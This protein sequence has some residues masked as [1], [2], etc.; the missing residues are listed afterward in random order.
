MP[1]SHAHELDRLPAWE[2]GTVAVLSTAG[3]GPPHAIPV[4]TGVRVGDH[5]LL[6]ALAL[7]RESLTRLRDDPS[8]ALT[9]LARGVACTAHGTA[10]ILQDPMAISDKVAAVAVDISSI[11]DHD[12]PRFKIEAGVSWS[13]TDADA[14]QRDGEIRAALAQLAGGA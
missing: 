12:Q 11:Q 2:L 14:E 8:C 3:S 13:W 1:Q 5:R 10:R 4:S 9:I 7:R 6:L